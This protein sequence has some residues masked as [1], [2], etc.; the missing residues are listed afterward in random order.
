MPRIIDTKYMRLK[1]SMIKSSPDWAK[2]ADIVTR[3]RLRNITYWNAQHAKSTDSHLKP[4]EDHLLTV[5]GRYDGKLA[6]IKD[7]ATIYN[8]IKNLLIDPEPPTLKNKTEKNI[9]IMMITKETI[10]ASPKD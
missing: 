6:P 1:M 5:F 9:T 3:L 10:D 2:N 4:L 7:I 8:R